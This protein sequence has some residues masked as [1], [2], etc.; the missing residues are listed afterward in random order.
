[1]LLKKLQH[2][3][4]RVAV[5]ESQYFHGHLAIEYEGSE[6]FYLRIEDQVLR[7]F[8]Y[9]NEDLARFILRIK[10]QRFINKYVS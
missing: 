5:W 8:S 4:K 1:M 3:Q 2:K 9:E 10:V 7:K 6:L